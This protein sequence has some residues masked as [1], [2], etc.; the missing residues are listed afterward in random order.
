MAPSRKKSRIKK[1]RLLVRLLNRQYGYFRRSLYS[2]VLLI[3]GILSVLLLISYQVIFRTVNEVYINTAIHQNGNNLGSIVEGALYNS[4]LENNKQQLQNTLDIIN[5]MPG[6]DDVSMYDHKGNLAYA[7]F[8]DGNEGH[9]NPNC[10]ECHADF[11]SM[12]PGMEK[13]YRIIRVNDECQ[14]NLPNSTSRH[15]LIHSPILNHPSCYNNAACHAHTSQDQILGALIIK[16]PLKQI[17]AAV[18]K[19]STEYTLL[20]IFITLV[21]ASFLILFTIKRIKDPLN[22]VIDVSKAIAT[23]DTSIRLQIK[24]NELEDITL[25]SITFNQMLDKLEAANTELQNWSKQL[26]YKVQKKSEEL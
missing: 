3:I 19:S 5:T 22:Q 7:S 4:M 25:L 14:M 20:G 6:I 13:S 21:F 8:A 18:Q 1:V 12:F 17:D 23:G 26:E 11:M 10:L 9:I 16:M 15:L 24:P 2:R